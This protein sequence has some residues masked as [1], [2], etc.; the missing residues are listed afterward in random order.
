MEV[1]D[2]RDIY[3]HVLKDQATLVEPAL[4]SG[5]FGTHDINRTR[6]K[7]SEGSAG[8][9]G[10]YYSEMGSI[11]QALELH[12]F[13]ESTP[14]DVRDDTKLEKKLQKIHAMIKIQR[15]ARKDREMEADRSKRIA[16]ALYMDY[17]RIDNVLRQF[18]PK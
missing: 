17:S 1:L 8:G 7:F 18:D 16:D 15:K 6:A 4:L 5:F 3:I 11:N 9:K 12:M 14:N 10:T 13:E 2:E